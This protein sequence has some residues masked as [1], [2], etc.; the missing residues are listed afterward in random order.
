MNSIVG[1]SIF[2]N[3][4]P[5][6]SQT[7][8][9]AQKRALDYFKHLQHCSITVGETRLEFWGHK[10]IEDR[11]QHLP[12]GS[13]LALIGSPLGSVTLAD[14]VREF[15]IPRAMDDFEPTWDG[16]F[17]LLHVDVDGKSWR[18]WNDFAGSIPVFHVRI[19]NGRIASTLE[20]VTVAAA[21]YT[22]D[23]FFMPG[24]VS[25]LINGHFLSD[26]T[27]YEGMN[28]ILPDSMTLWD[29]EG[30]RTKQLWTVQPSQ[31]RWEAGWNDLVDE[32]YALSRKAIT[33]ALSTQPR[34]NVPLSSGLDSRLIA[35]VAADVGA[36]VTTY[37]WG[38]AN[39]TDVNYSRQ[40]AR[41]LGL[42]WTH[43]E[44]PD[45]FLEK[46]TRRWADLFGSAM[47]FHG[48][49]QMCFLDAL[50]AHSDASLLSGFV[51]DVLAGD[52]L[53]SIF[54]ARATRNSQLESDWYCH[55]TVEM[56]QPA[57][58]FPLQDA[59]EANAQNLAKQ[60]EFFP[61]A[62]FQKLQYLELWN[63]QHCFT[64]FSSTLFDYWTGVTPPFI[65]RA[66]ARFCLSVPRVV[67]DD[68]H[69]L[70]AVF[71]R[72]YGRLAV[73]PG[74]YAKDPF[75]LTGKYLLLRRAAEMLPP[76]LHVGPLRGFGRVQLRMDIESVQATGKAALWPLFEMQDQLASWLDI[77]QI[78]KDY[79]TI[80]R[81]K[82][83]IRPL[84]R[85]QAAQTL[86]YRLMP[87]RNSAA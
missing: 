12:D 86:A 27:L 29:E 24:L 2:Y 28:T 26:W 53:A 57:A 18:M 54:E 46:N 31:S 81:S 85:L 51:G 36:D 78:E 77:S 74:T 20:P 47:V 80:M 33:D 10:Q 67:L 6:K 39:S 58:K 16:R 61:G 14:L 82:E 62:Y 41:S 15:I 64:N 70:G 50:K 30:F 23:D 25:L 44:S 9:R 75:I 56:L 52:G 69:L 65:N 84:R 7:A 43:I 60:I 71:R 87:E 32:M 19:E 40:I 79:Q 83:D 3:L 21:G 13:I 45:D 4:P 59:L 35:G 37:A 76:S 48:M 73:I 17:I 38:E 34:W 63:R 11:I 22:S 49:Y 66:Y 8:L 5:P 1:F 42:P 72:Y 68:R 55:W